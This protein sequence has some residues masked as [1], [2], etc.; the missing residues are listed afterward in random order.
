MKIGMHTIL[1]GKELAMCSGIR[2]TDDKGNM[3]F[4]RN[5][6]WNCGYGQKVTVT[7]RGYERRYAFGAE[8]RQDYAVIGPC[9]VIG[10]VPL[11]FDCA[12]E[13][14][15]AIAGL[16]FPGYAQFEADAVDGKTNLAAYEFP[17][18]V[19]SNFATV[20]ELE[21]A[22]ADVAIVAKPVNDQFPVALLH[23]LIGDKDRSIVVEYMA[24]GMRVH[25]DDVDVLTNQ[26][27]F[28]WHVEHL[29]SYMNLSPEY[30]ADVQ[31]GKQKL[32][33]YGSGGQLVGLP[34]SSYSPDRFVRVAYLNSHYPQKSGE[35]DNVSRMFHP[36]A[37]VAMIDGEAKM[38]NGEFE[39]TV[40]TG[41]ISMATKT[42]YMNTY[43]N[44]A[45]E[46]YPMDKA[47]LDGS[48]LYV[49]A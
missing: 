23:Y 15:L 43:E 27:T 38:E 31:W 42:Y 18:W 26:P 10:G 34:G 1:R 22:L 46:A 30:V 47:D 3:Y 12:N 17:L 44:P 39:T 7:P 21:E 33:P 8:S 5:L 14:G 6:D 2:F 29:R 24:D 49:F 40:Y 13:K 9:I 20:D 41:G 4:A 36:L 32:A 37:G 45:I 25:H 16:N 28:D 35:A 19:A 48:E 11:Y